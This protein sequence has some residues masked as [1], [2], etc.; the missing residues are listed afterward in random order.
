MRNQQ[1]KGI[2]SPQ[3]GKLGRHNVCL[4]VFRGLVCEVEIL[5]S[6][7]NVKLEPVKWKLQGKTLQL[8]LMNCLPVRATPRWDGLPHKVVRSFSL[9]VLKIGS[10]VTWKEFRKGHSNI[11]W[12][13]GLKRPFRL[14]PT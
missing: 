8:S 1:R 5:R 6:F 2:L 4:H 7:Q 9:E 12:V 10:R 14:L 11:W 13:I 3:K